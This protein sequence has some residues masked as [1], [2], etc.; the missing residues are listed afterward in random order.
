MLEAL[1]ALAGNTVVAAATTDAWEAARR[2]AG[3]RWSARLV[4]ARCRCTGWCR[5]SLPIRL[6]P[7]LKIVMAIA[8][9]HRVNSGHPIR[10]IHSNLQHPRAVRSL[11]TSSTT[12]QSAALAPACP[13]RRL[14]TGG[15]PLKPCLAGPAANP[16]LMDLE[17]ALHPQSPQHRGSRSSAQ[18]RTAFSQ[19]VPRCTTAG[20][21][22]C[23]LSTSARLVPGLADS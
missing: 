20:R 23:V 13:G 17:T 5:R 21:L 19:E 12:S 22:S 14:D 4:G 15:T 16:P 7:P 2:C 11:P 10:P 6:A 3:F 9:K 1:I 18:M 8:D